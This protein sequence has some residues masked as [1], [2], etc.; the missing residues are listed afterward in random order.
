MAIVIPALSCIHPTSPGEYV[1]LEM[2][3][4]L[5][6]G[7][8]DAYTL[9]HGVHWASVSA[10]YDRHGE[11]DIVIVNSAGDV[12]LL[13]IK[14]GELS[15]S[16]GGIFKRYGAEQKDVTRQTDTQF[17]S[18]QHRLRTA[19]LGARLLHFLV[20]P[21]Q[22]VEQSSGIGFPRERIADA[23][24]CED[25]AGFIQRRLGAGCA[26]PVRERVCAFF[27]NRLAFDV[28]VAALAGRL[29]NRVAK[30]SGGLATWVARIEAPS[31]VIRVRASAGSGKTQ[32][33]LR[34][35]RD[36]RV[37]DR[38]AAYICFNRPLADH[39]RDI[40]PK[41]VQVM[42][43]HQ[44]C[45]ETAGR[46]SGQPNF[47]VLEQ[48][49][50][51]HCEQ[52]SPDLDLLIIDELQDQQV[53]W[54]QALITRL[55]PEAKL[56]LLDDPSQCLYTDRQEIEVADE[57]VVRSQENFRSPQRL[58]DTIN[59]LSLTPEPVLACSPFEGEVPG[60]H[61]HASDDLLKAT[62]QAVQ[63]C[64]DKG[65]A[66]ADIVVLCWRGRERSQV[67]SEAR[68]GGWSTQRFDGTYDD[69]GRPSWTDGELRVET[70]RRFKGQSAPAIVLT[71]VNFE[72]L[73][74]QECRLLFVGMTRASM[75]LELVMTAAAE[76]ALAARLA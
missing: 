56:F 29:K 50:V 65:F 57:V 17:S 2:L 49:Y 25:L 72:Q 70:L 34:L 73:A 18:V 71:E 75:H 28:D 35:L 33:A 6:D 23:G 16:P 59:A 19:G 11:L 40:A 61:V 9:F 44:L 32:L 51:R 31:G 63:R 66:L 15:L 10:A 54:V 4:L 37:A 60:L 30:V 12:A 76:R 42:S 58:V 52:A 26:D 48:G 24:D 39:V 55:Q 7:L 64:I 47:S 69:Q 67:M 8:P 14:A 74:P 20:L 1:E 3:Q 13:E 53:E 21:N 41:G 68:L 27:E 38:S 5:A 22:R 46:P 36:A 43:F 45:W 62:A